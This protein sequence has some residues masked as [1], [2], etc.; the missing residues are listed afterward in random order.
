[1][2]ATARV[3]IAHRAGRDVVVDARSEPPYAVR[4]T[5][6]RVLL[7]GSAAAP[8]GGDELVLDV[9]IGPGATGVIGTAAA[10]VVWPGEVG[11][12][13]WSSS[14]ARLRVGDGGH[15]DWGP[16]P[17]VSVVG[18]RHRASTWVDLVGSATA[19]IVDEVSLGRTG[20]PPGRLDVELRVARDGLPLVHH[21]ERL[22]PDVPGWSSVVHLGAAR[23]LLTAVHVGPPAPAP[24]A[25]VGSADGLPDGAACA[26][27]PVA[28]DTTVILTVAPDRPTAHRAAAET[29]SVCRN[30]RR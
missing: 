4:T 13:A 2:R 21:L 28:A 12:D 15:L 22:G 5:R 24:Q 18:S 19:T 1:M 20:E 14:I 25:R 9:L 3:E 17:V 29:G 7:V 30:R 27:L 10:T 6:D 26:V 16:E 8:V 11:R 23:H